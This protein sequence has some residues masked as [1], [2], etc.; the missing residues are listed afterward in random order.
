MTTPSTV[1]RLSPRCRFRTVGDE[2][3]VVRL[4][5]AEVVAVNG[6]GA[7][8]L[9]LMRDGTKSLC[10]IADAVAKS[11]DVDFSTAAVDTA[12][13]ADELAAAGVV[14]RVGTP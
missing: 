3:V 2:G 14:E 13:F 1:Y 11:F 5:A 10:E 9:E 8:I 4:D 12:A 6:I 7:T